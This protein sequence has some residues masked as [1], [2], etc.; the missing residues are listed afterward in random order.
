MPL[1]ARI[2]LTVPFIISKLPVL[3]RVEVPVPVMLPLPS[4]VTMP[5]VSLWFAPR[6]KSAVVPL[7]VKLLVSAIALLMP[8]VS[9]PP[10]TT[11][12]PV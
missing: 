7:T 5:T 1:P 6:S 9:V 10:V 8:S 3:V 11:V 12:S 4:S 2:A